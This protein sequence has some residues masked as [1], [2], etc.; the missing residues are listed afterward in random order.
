M[1][2][3]VHFLFGLLLIFLRGR[4]HFLL[5][6]RLLENLRLFLY[7]FFCGLYRGV[8]CNW[9]GNRN[10]PRILHV[11]VFICRQSPT[12]INFWALL[13]ELMKIAQNRV[14]LERFES[15]LMWDVKSI[16]FPII[17]RQL[18]PSVC[19]FL[20]HQTHWALYYIRYCR[21]LM[22]LLVGVVICPPPGESTD[23]I[24]AVNSWTSEML[25]F[26]DLLNIIRLSENFIQ[27]VGW[28]AL[29]AL[30][31]GLNF[32]QPKDFFQ[33]FLLIIT[34]LRDCGVPNCLGTVNPL[35]ICLEVIQEV[36]RQGRDIFATF[37]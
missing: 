17:R 16:K 36:F 13:F 12:C 9:L 21:V 15:C 3:H 20:A 34:R 1:R 29:L 23:E 10:V 28:F 30:Y 5:V 19:N 33:F 4:N 32:P 7:W 31:F 37:H 25:F 27:L 26:L 11:L 14:W 24:M 35:W 22:V 6:L 18:H 2:L 8:S